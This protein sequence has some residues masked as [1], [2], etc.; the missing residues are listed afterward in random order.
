MR[1]L[2]VPLYLPARVG[3]REKRSLLQVLKLY[4]RVPSAHHVLSK[5]GRLPD[6]EGNQQL[7]DE[8]LIESADAPDQPTILPKP[9]APSTLRAAIAGALARRRAQPA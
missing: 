1:Q 9:Y 6:A 2:S 7:L 4:P 8:A 5:S 3:Q